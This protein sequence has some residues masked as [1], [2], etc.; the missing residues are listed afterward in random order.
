MN[1]LKPSEALV[2]VGLLGLQ[3]VDDLSEVLR[4]LLLNQVA[5][6]IAEHVAEVSQQLSL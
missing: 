1:G 5:V 6:D 2:A 3:P 4:S